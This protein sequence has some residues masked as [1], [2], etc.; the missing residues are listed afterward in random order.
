[1]RSLLKLYHLEKQN[2]FLT[3]Q[4]LPVALHTAR[5]KTKKYCMVIALHF[6]CFCMALRANSNFSLYII[7]NLVFINEVESVYSAV[8]TGS[9]N[10]AVCAW[11]LKG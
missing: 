8:R 9:L 7:N 10:K 4:N 1:M 5:F 6:I 11:A 3:F 2:N